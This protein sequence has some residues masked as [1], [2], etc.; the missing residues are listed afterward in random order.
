MFANSVTSK[1]MAKDV[2][3]VYTSYALGDYKETWTA[4]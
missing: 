4:F 1:Q 2:D 3:F